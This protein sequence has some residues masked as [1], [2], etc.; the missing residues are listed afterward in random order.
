MKT[1]VD[2]LFYIFLLS[3][4]TAKAHPIEQEIKTTLSAE[5]WQEDLRYLSLSITRGH[6]NPFTKVSKTEFDTAV[7]RFDESIP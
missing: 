1:I 2:V 4:L 3:L 5:Q 7:R 6:P